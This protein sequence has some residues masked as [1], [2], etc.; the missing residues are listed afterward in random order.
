MAST[1]PKSV[2]VDSS[3]WIASANP[4]DQW[5]S[6]AK[7]PDSRLGPTILVTTDAVLTEFL[8]ALSRSGQ[9]F[10][11]KAVEMVTTIMADPNNKV[12]PQTRELFLRGMHL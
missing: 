4:R 9:T 11:E 1:I 5:H 2:F 12:I 8:T 7:N 6:A 10:R 3:Y